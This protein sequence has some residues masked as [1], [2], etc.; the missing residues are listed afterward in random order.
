MCFGKI[1]KIFEI[2]LKI[3]KFYKDLSQKS[4]FQILTFV[5]NPYRILRFSKLKKNF[6]NFP[7][8]HF[9]SKI[10]HLEKMFKKFFR[11][12]MSIQNFPKIPKIILIKPCD[13]AKDTK[14][15]QYGFSLLI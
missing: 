5:T 12:P 11:T 3:S 14:N 9:L 15:K 1:L 8:T 2:F 13:Q 4:I 7:K 10:F 6:K